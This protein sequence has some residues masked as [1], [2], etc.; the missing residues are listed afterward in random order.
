MKNIY[1]S[2]LFIATI[3]AAASCAKTVGEGTNVAKKR[4]F[5]AWMHINHP[6]LTPTWNGTDS[7]VGI[8]IMPEGEVAGDGVQVEKDGFA[9]VDYTQYSLDGDIVEYTSAETAKQLGEFDYSTYYGPKVLVTYDDAIPA[10]VRDAM[11]TMKVGG[12]RKVIIPSWLMTYSTYGTANAYLEHSCDFSSS[13]YE[14][15]VKDFCDTIS[16][17][18]IKSIKEYIL[19]NYKT[20]SAFSNDTTGFYFKADKIY[21]AG[22]EAFPKDTT[23]Y[24][25]YTGKLLNGQVFDTTIEDVAKD[26]NI[27]SASKDYEPVRINW[28][29]K[30]SELSMG[31]DESSTVSGF[32]MTLWRLKHVPGNSEWKDSCTG[33]FTSSLGYGYSGSGSSIPAYAPLIFE[34]EVVDKPE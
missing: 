21:P 1:K 17:W 19:E 6:N 7:E 10:G 2:I 5:D 15:E 25:N 3:A 4:Y 20:E 14:L 29:E 9:I 22:A 16:K 28:G 34:I 13:I 24:I 11:L 23:I 32:A 8:Y 27:Y 31:T 30:Y 12:K 33:I 26:N 18:E